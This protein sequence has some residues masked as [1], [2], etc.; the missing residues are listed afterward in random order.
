MEVWTAN[1]VGFCPGVKRAF[2][3]PFVSF[4][5]KTGNF[6]GE[7]VH[8]SQAVKMLRRGGGIIVTDPER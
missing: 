2:D 1:R 7:L 8:N 4:P 6:L 5:G 3:L